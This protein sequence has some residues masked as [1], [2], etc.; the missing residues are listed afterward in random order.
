MNLSPKKSIQLSLQ[1][2]YTPVGAVNGDHVNEN[3]FHSTDTCTWSMRFCS[4]S[5]MFMD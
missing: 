5:Q 4:L 3:K 1:P 2:K